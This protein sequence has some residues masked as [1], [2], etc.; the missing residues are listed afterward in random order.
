M[1]TNIG[2]QLPFFLDRRQKQLKREKQMMNWLEK[3]SQSRSRNESGHLTGTPA[4][5]G[6]P[7]KFTRLFTYVLIEER[8]LRNS[9][10]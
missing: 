5:I 10:Y 6:W 8:K 7:G 3:R 4:V 9:Y 2:L 1:Y